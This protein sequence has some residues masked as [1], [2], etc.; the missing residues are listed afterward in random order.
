[1]TLH[2]S[3]AAIG[4]ANARNN[5]R[6]GTG[7]FALLVTS[8]LLFHF[9]GFIDRA[10][11]SLIDDHEILWPLGANSTATAAQVWADLKNTDE[12]Q[13]LRESGRAH[14]FRPAFYPIR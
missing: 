7:L 9:A 8:I 14:R 2:T 13:E 12:Y 10:S 4:Q 1:V 3:D 5:G 6:I 11:P